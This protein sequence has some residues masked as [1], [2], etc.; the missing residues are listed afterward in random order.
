MRGGDESRIRRWVRSLGAPLIPDEQIAAFVREVGRVP[1]HEVLEDYAAH[2]DPWL[3]AIAAVHPMTATPTRS[4]L[5]RD[6]E[7]V[8]RRLARE[9][10]ACSSDSRGAPAVSIAEV[11]EAKPDVGATHSRSVARA[12]RI[13]DAPAAG[14][15]RLTDEQKA[16]VK[17]APSSTAL[18]QAFA[19]TG[20][21]ST[22]VAYAEAWPRMPAL[23]LAFNAA[24]AR[25]AKAKFPAQVEART[26]HSLAYRAMYVGSHRDRLVNNLRRRDLVAAL[27]VIGVAKPDVHMVRMLRRALRRFLIGDEPRPEVPEAWSKAR[28]SD[29]GPVVAAIDAILRFER[30]GLPFTHDVY[31]KRM[32]LVGHVPGGVS[33]LMVDEAQDLNPVLIGWLKRTALPL[34]VVGD[35]WQSIYAFR[36]AVSAMAAFDAP[37]YPLTLSWRFGQTLAALANRLLAHVSKPPRFAVRGNPARSTRVA[38]AT[39]TSARRLVL[40]RTN[41]GAF[42]AILAS[43]SPFHVEGGFDALAAPLMAAVRLKNGEALIDATGGLDYATWEELVEEA[44]EGDAEAA[45]LKALVDRFGTSLPE[46]LKELAQRHVPLAQATIHVSTAHKAKGLEADEVEMLNDFP[47]LASLDG[48]D[49]PNGDPKAQMDPVARDQEIHLLYVAATRAKLTLHAPEWLIDLQAGSVGS[50]GRVPGA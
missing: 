4:R 49:R 34:I 28:P 44:I 18:V 37:M 20:K 7:P 31:L 1:R 38:R 45:R 19:G 13:Q 32:A 30:S 50:R 36:G 14:A 11:G 8:V 42:E 47:S 27:R 26:A 23:Y 35:P 48:R 43:G 3:R 46:L 12:V 25:E 5:L 16:I 17:H 40:G 15:R 2:G 39:T 29:V 41:A 6:E 22:L 33:Y 10:M 24:I 21:T 9:A